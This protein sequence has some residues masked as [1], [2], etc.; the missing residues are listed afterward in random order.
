VRHGSLAQSSR[1]VV[2][3][4]HAQIPSRI[5]ELVA[6]SSGTPELIAPGIRAAL[7]RIDPDLPV[8]GA[9]PLAGIVR[10]SLFDAQLELGL[11][12]LF[13]AVALGLAASG[14]YAV[15]AYGIA[16]R[17]QEFGIRVALGA[18]RLDILRLVAG[19]GLRL[20][21]AGIGIGLFG[22]WIASSALASELYGIGTK[23]PFVYGGTALL[24]AAVALAA[25]L[26]PTRRAISVDPIVALRGE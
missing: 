16:L 22:A 11:L 3:F 25:C 14:I 8:D 21:A 4:P 7:Q 19:A 15:I 20:T 9:R 24:L 2:Y 12:G 6:R 10:E 18:T 13:A 17:R 5:M 1:Q 26:I 23:D